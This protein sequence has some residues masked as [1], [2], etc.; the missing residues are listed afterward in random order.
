MRYHGRLISMG[1]EGGG[2]EGS[3]GE[4]WEERRKGTFWLDYKNKN[5]HKNKKRVTNEIIHDTQLV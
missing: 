1:G 4:D 3:R 2:V 5:I